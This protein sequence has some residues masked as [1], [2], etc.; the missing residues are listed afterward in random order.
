VELPPDV[1]AAIE[2]A[3]LSGWSDERLRAV[4]AVCAWNTFGNDSERRTLMAA[5][6]TVRAELADRVARARHA[7]AMLVARWIFIAGVLTL[8]MAL[9][10]LFFAARVFVAA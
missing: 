3:D 9:L 4:L 5:E 8:V 6:T 7:E 1:L 2:S 10:T